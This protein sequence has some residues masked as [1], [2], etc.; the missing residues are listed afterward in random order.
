MV[1]FV[2]M[3]PVKTIPTAQLNTSDETTAITSNTTVEMNVLNGTTTVKNE[4]TAAKSEE[5][6]KKES[7]AGAYLAA[8]ASFAG[9][10]IFVFYKRKREAEKS[11]FEPLHPNDF[12]QWGLPVTEVEFDLS[13]DFDD[14]DLI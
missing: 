11:V 10:G 5:P 9:V 4:T 8:A 13:H 3:I 7:S 14:S 6:A 1:E 12:V 2:R